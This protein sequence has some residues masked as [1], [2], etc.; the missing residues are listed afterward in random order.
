MINKPVTSYDALNLV[1]SY[2]LSGN[3]GV[4]C[5][6]RSSRLLFSN[7]FIMITTCK[8]ILELVKNGTTLP[9]SILSLSLAFEKLG[10]QV[11]KNIF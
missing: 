7:H 8:N 10:K 9:S 11:I 4:I 2:L 6:S 1:A 3:H 5:N